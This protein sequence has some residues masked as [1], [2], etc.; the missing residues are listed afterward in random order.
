MREQLARVARRVARRSAKERCDRRLPRAA[1]ATIRSRWT[2]RSA[3]L[4]AARPPC[5]TLLLRGDRRDAAARHGD[6]DAGRDDRLGRAGRGCSASCSTPS[7]RPRVRRGSDRRCC[8]GAEVTLLG[9]EAPGSA[10]RGRAVRAPADA[11]CPTCP[12]G[13]RGSGRRIGVSRR[14]RCAGTGRGGAAGGA[15]GAGMGRTSC[16]AARSR[17]GDC[18]WC[19]AN[20]GDL[21]SRAQRRPRETRMA[22]QAGGRGAR[23]AADAGGASALRGGPHGLPE[24]C[25]S[26]PSARRARPRQGRAA[27]R[28]VARSRWRPIPSI[29]ARIVLNGKEGSVG[30]MPPLGSILTDEQIAVGAHLHSA[31]VGPYGVARRSGRGRTDATGNRGP[32]QTL[33]HG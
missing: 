33:D 8:K 21:S 30:L 6:H 18:R 15:A 27:A 16:V 14:A 12:G 13:A 25:A 2:R 28:R 10:G 20:G 22:R 31:R 4:P 3:A 5:S 29:P 11:P 9:A 7:P 19:A 1:R 23:H 24:L 17:A 32:H 26:V